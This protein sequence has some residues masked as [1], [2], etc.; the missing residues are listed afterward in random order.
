MTKHVLETLAEGS[1]GA[2]AGYLDTKYADKKLG[3]MSYG[4]VF[5]FAGV[6]AGLLGSSMPGGADFG[7][8]LREAGGGAGAFEIGK[9]V[10]ERTAKSMQQSGT[11]TQAQLRGRVSG[12]GALP[13]GRAPLTQQSL[14]ASIAALRAR[15]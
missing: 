5:A 15:G 6:A 1:G 11:A 8:Y 2:L 3:G 10:A 14:Q 7:N 12:V 4:T 9:I 13:M